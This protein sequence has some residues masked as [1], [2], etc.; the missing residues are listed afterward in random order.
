M[1]S[2]LVFG[3]ALAL[4]LTTNAALAEPTRQQW[5]EWKQ[6]NESAQRAL[7]EGRPGDAVDALRRADA[8]HKS[9][10][11]D[12]SLAGALLAAGR[13]VEAH[14][15]YTTVA[16]STDPG[17]LWKRARDAAK[18]ALLDLSPR[19]PSLRVVLR[20]PPGASL[21]IDG[22]P[23]T[24]GGDLLLDPGQHTVR[25]SGEGLAPVERSVSLAPGERSQL[26]LELAPAGGGTRFEAASA[27]SG[28]GS[29]VPGG[30]LL[31]VGGAALA[32]GGVMGGVA[33]SA[34]GAAKDHCTGSTC[35][36]A[37]AADIDRSKLFGN[38]STGLVIAG[39]AVA[40]AGIVLAVVAPGGKKDDAAKDA[41]ITPILGPGMVGVA[42]RF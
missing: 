26:I 13:L 36:P 15:V 35:S 1:R 11:L 32:V 20:G 38:A 3:G 31:G 14:R 24:S 28:G 16:G 39:G 40:V 41:R 19:V 21:S 34:A 42:G 33:L 22:A 5:M 30:I 29:R 9:P 6:L 12:V 10:T 7:R 17:I 27:S 4:A 2:S 25:A 37:A 18:K 23:A 8:I